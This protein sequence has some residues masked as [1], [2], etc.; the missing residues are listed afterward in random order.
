MRPITYL[1]NLEKMKICLITKNKFYLDKNLLISNGLLW[2]E[3]GGILGFKFEEI[4]KLILIGFKV[5]EKF[6]G[7]IY[8]K[9]TENGIF[10]VGPRFKEEK[11]YILDRL[12]NI[13]LTLKEIWKNRKILKD[14]DLVYAPFFEYVAFEFLLLKLIC[15]KSK[16]IVYIIGDYPEWNYRKKR[17]ILLKIFLL[18]SQKT[19]QM[20]ADESWLLSEYL[21]RK[22]KTKNSVLIR[23]SSI[24]EKDILISKTFNN[25]KIVLVFLGRFAEE[26]NPYLPILITVK[27]KE[28]GYNI[29]LNLVGDGA[30]KNKIE[31]LIQDF[32]L[33]NN[34][35]MWG[36]LKNKEQM[37][38]IL[39]NSDI[40][41][42]TSKQ[43]EGLG[44]VILEAMSQGLPV[45]A[46]KCGGPEEII[47]D[48][49]NG[50]LI[51][52]STDE[53]I[54]SQFVNKI[55]FLIKNPKIYEEISKNN[56]EK[57]KT[58]TMGEFSKIQRER[59]LKLLKK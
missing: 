23:S 22:Y 30:L 58:W 9:G 37:F 32:K 43:G 42:F 40:L 57:S 12:I 5:N 27:L 1:K 59:I 26:K 29:F 56:I 3:E 48:K 14:V 34:V 51:D 50:Y 20:L 4:E 25:K 21:M 52:Y 47:M 18:I 28:K 7:Y 17:S 46:T 11:K 24:S 13:F 54:V 19:S 6:D 38:K 10:V 15:K 33:N 45:I 49:I 55:E 31:K 16:F 39:R 2:Y 44:L 41:L 8:N 36:W 53:K 35:K